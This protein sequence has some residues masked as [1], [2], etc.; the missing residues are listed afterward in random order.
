MV[1]R[2]VVGACGASLIKPLQPPWRA[3][4]KQASRACGPM[5]MHPYPRFAGLPPEG[6][7]CST[8]TFPAVRVILSASEESWY[9]EIMR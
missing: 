3:K 9:M 4:G 6:E 1:Q 8:L 2:V 7:V 5:E